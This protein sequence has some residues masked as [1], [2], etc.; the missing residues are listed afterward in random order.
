MVSMNI[1]LPS[2]SPKH[3]KHKPK[4]GKFI[5]LLTFIAVIGGFLFGYDTGIV[6]ATMLYAPKN[7]DLKPMSN[8]WIGLIVSITPGMAAIGALLAGKA[9]DVFGRRK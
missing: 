3:P 5:Y 9:S 7:N 8:Q 6:S 1:G 4:L 2:T